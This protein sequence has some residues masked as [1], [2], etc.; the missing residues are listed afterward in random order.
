MGKCDKCGKTT[1][2]GRQVDGKNFC[3]QGCIDAYWVTCGK[4]G[5]KSQSD[6]KKCPDCGEY[7]HQFKT[8]D[9]VQQTKPKKKS[10]LFTGCAFFLSVFIGLGI[11]F[12]LIN[13]KKEKTEKM[14]AHPVSN[15]DFLQD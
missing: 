3:S 14:T 12:N 6:T 10:G 4:C 11:I 1:I 13:Q 2:G 15:P 8:G 7:L 9:L 5:T